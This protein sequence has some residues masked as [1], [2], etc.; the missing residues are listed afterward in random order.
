MSAIKLWIC[1]GW[2]TNGSNYTIYSSRDLVDFTPAE[3]NSEVTISSS[4]TYITDENKTPIAIA[5]IADNGE[6]TIYC[7]RYVYN[8]KEYMALD[9][10]YSGQTSVPEISLPLFPDS[11]CTKTT[12]H[13]TPPILDLICW[14]RK[15]VGR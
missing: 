4:A 12:A 2:I 5:R 6:S 13:L 8:E 1:S 7:Y 3:P 10:N 9:R 15:V 14:V 11:T